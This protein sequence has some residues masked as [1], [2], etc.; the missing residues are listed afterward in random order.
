MSERQLL[1]EVEAHLAVAIE[2]LRQMQ[3]DLPAERSRPTALV[4]TKLSYSILEV[5]KLVGL[6]RTTI[7]KAI[8]EGRLAV[9]KEG[10][11]TLVLASELSRWTSDLRIRSTILRGYQGGK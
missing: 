5:Q 7:F 9:V 6:G 4:T 8:K 2:L 3:A 1:N 10:S 11:R